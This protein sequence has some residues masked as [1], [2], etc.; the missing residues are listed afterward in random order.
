MSKKF[1]GMQERLGHFQ[2]SLV[3]KEAAT[4]LV[5]RQ[6]ADIP[7]DKLR[8]A[9]W[10]ARRYFDEKMIAELAADLQKNGQIQPIVVRPQGEDFEIIVGNRR[11]YA[12]PM[13]GMETLRAEIR[14]LDDLAARYF[15][16]AENLQREDLNPFEETLGYMQLL[17]LLLKDEESFHLF[18]QADEADEHAVGRLLR[19]YANEVERNENNVILTPSDGA[20]KSS[21]PNNQVLGTPMESVIQGVFTTAGHMTW[22]SFVKNRLPLL[23]MPVDVTE[24]VQ[25]GE[26]E[27]TKARKISQLKDQQARRALLTE[28]M[29]QGLSLEDVTHRVKA[30]R[31]QI[32]SKTPNSLDT[33]AARSRAI[34]QAIKRSSAL[35]HKAKLKRAER[36]VSELEALLEI[37]YPEQ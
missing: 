1:A 3:Q 20:P 22:Q 9:S 28:A 36:L 5:D 8:P 19:R 4:K 17:H 32:T 11:F 29:E 31:E 2:E 27:Y 14:A 13:A 21:G 35:E 26:L 12:A 18:K 23:Q 34:S 37:P 15:S 6:I 33:L 24:A 25:R 30:H 16:L 10:N 7:L